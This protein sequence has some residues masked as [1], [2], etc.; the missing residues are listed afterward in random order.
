MARDVNLYKQLGPNISQM[1]PLHDFSDL[2]SL[3]CKVLRQP[4]KIGGLRKEKG[5]E[6]KRKGKRTSM[7]L[8]FSL[9][10]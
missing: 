9:K 1:K 5:R 7:I 2:A 4:P 10:V 3:F 8:C 6:R